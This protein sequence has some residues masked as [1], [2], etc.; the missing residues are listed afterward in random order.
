MIKIKIASIFVEDQARALDFYTKT[1]GLVK[2]TDVPAGK[3]R[4]LTVASAADSEF[5][6]LLEPNAHPASVIF[7]KAI[8]SDGIPATMLFVD[9]IEAE[10]KRLKEVGVDFTTEPMDAGSVK[11]ATFDDTCGNLIQLV[12]E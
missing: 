1:L 7:Q 9:D 11:I 6:L 3:Y 8:Y 12:Q 5:E 2:K 10:F 4:W